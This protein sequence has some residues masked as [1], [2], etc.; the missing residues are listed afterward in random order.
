MIN[1]YLIYTPTWRYE[2]S[3]RTRTVEHRWAVEC[4]GRGNTSDQSVRRWSEN[5]NWLQEYP[6]VVLMVTMMR[7]N[8]Q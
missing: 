3:T 7:L 4:E 2:V 6:D 5:V 1:I 8:V